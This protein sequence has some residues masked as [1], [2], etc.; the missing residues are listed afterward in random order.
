MCWSI[1]EDWRI[2]MKNIFN[3]KLFSDGMRQ[4]RT[5]GIM[6]LIIFCLET[7]FIVIGNNM[8][9]AEWIA[10]YTA[11][12]ITISGSAAQTALNMP[13]VC[14]LLELHPILLAAIYI[15]VP[16]MVL[17]L[18]GFMNRRNSSDFYHSIPVKRECIAVSFL[19]AIV[20]W[21]C[22][23]VLVSTA[24]CCILTLFTPYVAINMY[25]VL[26][27][28][29]ATL[30]GSVCM[31]AAGF[32]AMSITGTYF[33][34]IAVSVM[35]LIFPRG[36]ITFFTVMMSSLVQVLPL[37]LG[38]ILDYNLNI[39]VG[40]VISLFISG[41][42]LY[43][44]T[45][46]VPSLYTLVLAIVYFVI[47]MYAFKIRKSETATMPASNRH[48]QN[49]YR[50]IPPVCICLLPIAA[51]CQLILRRHEM[52][53]GTN[54]MNL[55][56]IVLFYFI[57][58]IAY[59][60][61]ELISTRKIANVMKSF[62]SLW[63]LVAFNVLFV[64]IIAAGYFYE[65]HNVPS[66]DRV[67]YVIINTDDYSSLTRSDVE[68][69]YYFTQKA[70]STKIYNQEII[71]KLVSYLEQNI[72][73]IKTADDADSVSAYSTRLSVE[74]GKGIGTLRRKVYV[75]LNEY[76]TFIN[77]LNKSDDYTSIYKNLP[78]YNS[79]ASCEL[80]MTGHSSWKIS[81]NDKRDLY[82]ALCEDFR[83]LDLPAAISH[84]SRYSSGDC[85]GRFYVEVNYKSSTLNFYAGIS[86]DTPRA[87]KLLVERINAASDAS[88]AVNKLLDA[89]FPDGYAVRNCTLSFTLL[90]DGN[91]YDGSATRSFYTNLDGSNDSYADYTEN[92]AEILNKIADRLDSAPATI[93]L[94]RPVLCVTYDSSLTD[95]NA[96]HTTESGCRF[97][98]ADDELVNLFSTFTKTDVR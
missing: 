56:Y 23:I 21:L 31:L 70:A 47:G 2:I 49:I 65:I 19:A 59:F 36:L 87:L 67:K 29:L 30:A 53:G 44:M 38:G 17:Y 50:L 18:F 92:G 43:P 64:I 93:D 74:F 45:H 76:Q 11:G 94:N 40:N 26:T 91:L 57:A 5:I 83:S 61:Y 4:L 12:R 84:T 96:K 3:K 34:N 37:S 63:A 51:I 82:E 1:I 73:D 9:N 68:H 79:L 35:L 46:L 25:S 22:I 89:Q 62:K 13:E 52:F 58:V 69:D 90:Y 75:P 6:G 33:S 10:S 55:F 88:N 24:L 98:Q 7:V 16:V 86:A 71:S 72:N 41:D 20:T 81:D 39:V 54:A 8:N 14:T 27:T 42:A 97:Y 80:Y 15:L 77:T 85:I 95:N 66:A 28:T 48:L 78:E 32:L 60:L